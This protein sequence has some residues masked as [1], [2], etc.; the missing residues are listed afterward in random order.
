MSP[1]NDSSDFDNLIE[2]AVENA[3]NR[4]IIAED[5]LEISEQDSEKI[6]GG[7]QI[8]T[9]QIDQDIFKVQP[10]LAGIIDIDILQ[11]QANVNE[12]A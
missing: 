12:L 1:I 2:T 5:L 7:R 8:F 10:I 11:K 4:R 6:S 3:Q 9:P